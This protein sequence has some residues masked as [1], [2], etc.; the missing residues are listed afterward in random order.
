[1]IGIYVAVILIILPL[2]VILITTSRNP[3]I[4]AF[5]GCGEKKFDGL[6][7]NN[8]AEASHFRNTLEEANGNFKEE[9][10]KS[11]KFKDSTARYI[12]CRLCLMP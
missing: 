11:G 9:W 2:Y 8:I 6:F 3:D 4:N 5:S 10:S 7:K 1:M 12:Q